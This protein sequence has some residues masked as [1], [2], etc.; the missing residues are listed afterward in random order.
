M[1]QQL[2]LCLGI[3]ERIL[4]PCWLWD[5]IRN[6]PEGQAQVVRPNFDC[7]DWAPTP[8]QTGGADLLAP[9]RLPAIE[10][11][12]PGTVGIGDEIYRWQAGVLSGGVCPSTCPNHS[13]QG[14]M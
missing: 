3:Y 6:D 13:A 10:R 1:S 14:F 5:I 7:Q 11:S 8:K 9:R 4:G 2:H 12:T